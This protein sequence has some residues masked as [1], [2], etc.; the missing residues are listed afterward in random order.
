VFEIFYLK[1]QGGG[2]FHVRVDGRRQATVNTDA[3]ELQS[4]FHRVALK[5]GRHTVEIRTAAEQKVRL[6]GA[7]VERKGPGVVYD[8][9][10]ING[11]FFNTPLR[12]DETLLA[13]QIAERSPDLVI[14]MYGANEVDSRHLTADDYLEQVRRVMSRFMAAADEASCLMLAPMDRRSPKDTADPALSRLDV[15]I[16]VQRQVADEMGCGFID[17]KELMGGEGANRRWQEKRVAQ[18]DGVHLTISGYRMLGELIAELI[19][20]GYDRYRESVFGEQPASDK[21]SDGVK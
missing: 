6:F 14:A 2:R 8:T 10:G 5:E 11:A 1:Q 13:E 21:D 12:W 18:R 17:L 15:I 3:D 9:L 16:D 7:V 4:G 20:D 19:L